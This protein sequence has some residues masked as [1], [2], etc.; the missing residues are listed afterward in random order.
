MGYNSDSESPLRD[1]IFTHYEDDVTNPDY[2]PH[3]GESD[4][5]VLNFN[6]R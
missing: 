2:M 4:H 5:A 6:F 3:L 1:L